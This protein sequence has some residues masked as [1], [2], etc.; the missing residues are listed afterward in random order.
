MVGNAYS[1]T[2]FRQIWSSFRNT[3]GDVEKESFSAHRLTPQRDTYARGIFTLARRVQK[4][5]EESFQIK[6]GDGGEGRRCRLEDCDLSP[7]LVLWW[8]WYCCRRDVLEADTEKE[9]VVPRDSSD[10]QGATAR[11]A[12]NAKKRR[13]SSFPSP[14]TVSNGEPAEALS[15]TNSHK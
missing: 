6:E 3:W 14:P 1:D 11:G 12:K 4:G 9:E 13:S 7:P 8:W 15:I 2:W 5:K 10:A